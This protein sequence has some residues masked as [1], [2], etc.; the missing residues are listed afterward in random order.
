[1]HSGFYIKG[2]ILPF[3]VLRTKEGQRIIM[4]KIFISKEKELD[5]K[6]LSVMAA[7]NGLYSNKQEYLITSVNGIGYFL[8]GSF[9]NKSVKRDRNIADNIKGALQSL[10]DNKI[11]EILEQDGDNYIISNNGLEVDTENQKFVIVELWEIQHIFANAKM[12]FNLFTFFVDLIGTINNKTKEWHMSQDDMASQWG[13]SKRTVSDY[14][15]QLEEM[16]LIYLYKHRKRRTDGT[17]HKIN[18]SYGRYADSSFVIQEAEKYV[19]SVEC[20]DC[21][22]KIDRRS[23]KLRYNAFCKDAKRYQ[24]N[25]DVVEELLK[26]CQKYNKS[27]DYKPID[28]IGSDGKYK[29]ADKLDLS[30]FD[31]FIEVQNETGDWGEPDSMIY[32]NNIETCEKSVG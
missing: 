5:A 9:L 30:V 8:S 31:G 19:E 13:C 29:Q 28:E 2:Q 24:N 22:E 12:P 14:L 10:N 26:E 25:P 16:K 4:L 3:L 7:L 27:L 32:E 11:I 1:M 6:E 23:I 18:N 17:Y 20:E 21:Y 15:D